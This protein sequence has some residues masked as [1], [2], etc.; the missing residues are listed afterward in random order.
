MKLYLSLYPREHQ[1]VLERNLRVLNFL[2]S[3]IF[4]PIDVT[5]V[6]NVWDRNLSRA[7]SLNTMFLLFITLSSLSISTPIVHK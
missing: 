7:Q 5:S 3:I 2:L 1:R 4:A 6:S